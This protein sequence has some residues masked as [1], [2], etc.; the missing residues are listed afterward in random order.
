VT[1]NAVGLNISITGSGNTL[2]TTGV[3]SF[4]KFIA[5]GTLVVA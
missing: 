5:S 2:G 3:Y 1:A 4:A